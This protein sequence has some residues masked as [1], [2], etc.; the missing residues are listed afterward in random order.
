MAL[1]AQGVDGFQGRPV[2]CE[3]AGRLLRRRQAADHGVEEQGETGRRF[4]GP[5]GKAGTRQ[6]AAAGAD[7]A[8]AAVAVDR[9]ADT[10]VILEAAIFDRIDGQRQIRRG[11]AEPGRHVGQMVDIGPR[12]RRHSGRLQKREAGPGRAGR[13]KQREEYRAALRICF[14]RRGKGPPVLAVERRPHRGFPVPRNAQEPAERR[15]QGRKRQVDRQTVEPDVAQ[16]PD[17]HQDHFGIGRRPGRADQ[18]AADLDELPL[19]PELRAPHPQHVAGI[20]QAQ[21]P[22]LRGEP[23]G[24]DPGDLQRHV[25]AHAHHRLADRIHQPEGLAGHRRP[26][27]FEQRRLELDERRLDPPVAPAG[28]TIEQPL[29]DGRFMRC[30]RRQHVAQAGRQKASVVGSRHGRHGSIARGTPA[31]PAPRSAGLSP[32]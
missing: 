14:Q 22:G 7:L 6:I 26:G 1:P 15:D 31:A 25:G 27:A 16:G 19:R 3:Q 18:L 21:G 29:D 13:I 20:G 11:G 30:V 5:V 8:P 12:L 10:G 24:G 9:E 4:D 32:V 2:G 28:E 17:R 23:A